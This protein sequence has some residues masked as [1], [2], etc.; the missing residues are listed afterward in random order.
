MCVYVR[1]CERESERETRERETKHASQPARER[2][3][4]RDREREKEGEREKDTQRE[5]KTERESTPSLAQPR[6]AAQGACVCERGPERKNSTSLFTHASFSVER[7]YSRERVLY[8]ERVLYTEST[9][10]ESTLPHTLDPE[11]ETRNPKPWT[12]NPKS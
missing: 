2:E 6:P 5:R 8:K 4:A 9:L 10:R 12:I 1:V 3:R 7:D 11:P